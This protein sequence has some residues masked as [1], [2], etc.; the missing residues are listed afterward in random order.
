MEEIA[1][2]VF[3]SKFLDMNIEIRYGP[4]EMDGIWTGK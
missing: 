4:C 1:I 3:K 2:R